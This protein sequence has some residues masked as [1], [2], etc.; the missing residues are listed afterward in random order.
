MR[1]NGKATLFRRFD[2]CLAIEEQMVGAEPFPVQG[3]CADLSHCQ[4]VSAVMKDPMIPLFQAPG[5]YIGCHHR[6]TI[7]DRY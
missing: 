4:L 7:P 5:Y 3:S 2:R 1:D 6:V